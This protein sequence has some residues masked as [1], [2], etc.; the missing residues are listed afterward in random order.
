MDCGLAQAKA[1]EGVSAD[2]FSASLRKEIVDPE[3]LE[4]ASFVK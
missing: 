4:G 1:G 2:E 3:R